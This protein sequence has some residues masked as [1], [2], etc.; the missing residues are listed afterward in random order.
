M[1][2][3]VKFKITLFYKHKLLDLMGRD[4]KKISASCVGKKT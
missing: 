4:E 3:A 2:K 1:R